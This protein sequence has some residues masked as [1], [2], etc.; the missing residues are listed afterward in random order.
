M[1]NPSR[2]DARRFFFETWQKHRTGQPL[3][4]L[5]TI[6]LSILVAHPEYHYIVEAPET[7][8]EAD[9]TPEMGQSN[10]FLHMSLHMAIEEQR[11]IDQ[12]FGIRALYAQLALRLGSEHD[13]QH[14]MMECLAEMI[15]HAQ[16][17][18]GGPDVNRYINAVRRRL[19]EGEEETP[20]PNPGAGKD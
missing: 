14:A 1:F 8:L 12:P 17:H 16:R 19:G 13:A 20:R 4:D 3:T 6:V 5:E 7:Y 11:S 9:W 10:P 18:G 2:Q 15:W